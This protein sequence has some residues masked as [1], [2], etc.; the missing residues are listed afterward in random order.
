[1]RGHGDH[2][3]ICRAIEAED[4][5]LAKENVELKARNELLLDQLPEGMKDC[6]IR[7]YACGEG[8]ARLHALNWDDRGCPTCQIDERDTEIIRLQ[9]VAQD[10]SAWLVDAKAYQVRVEK[11]VK[12]MAEKR[13]RVLE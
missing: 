3:S 2:C 8:H 7:F 11:A 9:V 12:A 5:V 1:M 4:Q 13:G 10:F 6:T